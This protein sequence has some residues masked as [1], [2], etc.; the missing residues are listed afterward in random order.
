VTPHLGY[1]VHHHGRG[2][3]HR[4]LAIL[5]QLRTPT[6]VLS[7]LELDQTFGDT[8]LP[9][10]G[11]DR[12][13]GA[14]TEVVRL[15]LDLPAGERIAAA[16]GRLPLPPVL[17]YAPIGVAGL[18]QRTAALATWF[19]TADPAV[20][21]VDVSVEVALLARLSGVAP[22]VVRQHGDRWD[23]GHRAA[24]EGAAALLAPWAPAFE[25][26]TAP[27][28]VRDRTW[29]VGGV[30]RTTAGAL[31]RAAARQ[32]AGLGTDRPAV[33]VLAGAGGSEV[34]LADLAG[35]ARATPDWRWTVLGIDPAR[36]GEAEPATLDVRGW[37]DDPGVFLRGADVVVTHAGHNAVTEAAVAGARTIVVPA[38]RPFAEQAHK[39]RQLAALGAAVVA[40]SWPADHRWPDLLRQAAALDPTELSALVGE[41]GARRAAGHLDGL[42]TELTA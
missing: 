7:S 21:V 38:A 34:S 29:Y 18:R 6:T 40:P 16:A 30:T 42:V 10:P 3:L 14:H 1:Y 35:A 13:D 12:R 8:T 19:T 23:P 5:P 4:A 26:P 17:H 2:H 27:Q 31:D 28:E 25:D 33:V 15:P 36:T 24:Y 41:G 22:V 9:A 11:D 37:I 20:L 39:A 32:Q